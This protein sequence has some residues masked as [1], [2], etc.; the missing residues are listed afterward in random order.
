MTKSN[1]I[2]AVEG[3]VEFLACECTYGRGP[4]GYGG[5]LYAQTIGARRFPRKVRRVANRGLDVRDS[6]VESAHFNIAA[7]I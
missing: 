1:R 5:R 6:D 3:V 2:K 4:I 7:H